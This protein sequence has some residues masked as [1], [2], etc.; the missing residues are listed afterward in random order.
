MIYAINGGP[1]KKW[2]TAQM[3]ESFIDGVKSVKPDEEIKVVHVYDLDYKGC[4]GCLG[5]KL[6][7]TPEGQCIVRDGAY[8]IL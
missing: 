5:C 8:N 2:N 1:R 3:L 6:K 7:T 4:R